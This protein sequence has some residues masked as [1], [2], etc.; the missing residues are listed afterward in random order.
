MLV[1]RQN[2]ANERMRCEFARYGWRA[3]C[4]QADILEWLSSERL[5]VDL[6][7]ANLFLHHFR[8]EDLRTMFQHASQSTKVFTACEP[9]RSAFS[10]MACKFLG[11]I[12]CNHVTRHD[13]EISIRAGFTNHELSALWPRNSD[14]QLKEGSAGLFSHSFVACNRAVEIGESVS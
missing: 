6:V 7:I 12:G 4:I 11:L 14:W 8:N 13:A 10:L 3:I 5:E 9:A 2:F 1:D